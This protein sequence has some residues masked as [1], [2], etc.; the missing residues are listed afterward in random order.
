MTTLMK[1][2][3]ASE[4]ADS[5]AAA[6][7]D[8]NTPGGAPAPAPGGKSEGFAASIKAALSE[9]APDTQTPN[10]PTLTLPSAAQPEEQ[11]QSRCNGDVPQVMPEREGD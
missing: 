9:K 4:P 11:P 5:G 10:P 7:A 1:R 2:L 3:R 8:P 6:A